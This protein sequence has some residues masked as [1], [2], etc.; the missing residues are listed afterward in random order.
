MNVSLK[1]HQNR[2]MIIILCPNPPKKGHIAKPGLTKQDLIK[3]RPIFGGFLPIPVGVTS[4]LFS[5]TNHSPRSVEEP[6]KGLLMLFES[7]C[8]SRLPSRKLT[9]PT[10]GKPENHGRKKCH[11]WDGIRDRSLGNIP[12]FCISGST[13]ETKSMGF[14]GTPNNGTPLWYASHTIPI[15]LP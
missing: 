11:P 1:H 6:E 10:L 12:Y 3:T 13:Q 5:M 7:C 2:W 8:G 15:P 9:Y 14:S 4:S